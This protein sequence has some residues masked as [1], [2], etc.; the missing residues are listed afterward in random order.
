MEKVAKT[1]GL[2]ATQSKAAINAVFD[3]LKEDLNAGNN[4]QLA[5]FGSF[6]SVVRAARK[7]RNPSTGEVIDIPSMQTVKFKPSTQ[8]KIKLE[9]S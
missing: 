4:T 1:T 6:N 5:G 2:N 7:G 3:A 9:E 8:L